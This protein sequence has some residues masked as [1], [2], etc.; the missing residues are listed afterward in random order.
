MDMSS[1]KFVPCHLYNQNCITSLSPSQFGNN[2]QSHNLYADMIFS[3]QINQVI[4]KV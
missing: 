1:L 3:I 4:R 2:S